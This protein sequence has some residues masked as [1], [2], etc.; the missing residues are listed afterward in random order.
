M[1][2]SWACTCYCVCIDAEKTR[3]VLC[4]RPDW[5]RGMHHKQSPRRRQS[6]GSGSRQNVPEWECN[7]KQPTMQSLIQ[8]VCFRYNTLPIVSRHTRIPASIDTRVHAGRLESKGPMAKLGQTLAGV[9]IFA[10]YVRGLGVK[11]GVLLWGSHS[12]DYYG[13]SSP[14]VSLAHHLLRWT[15]LF[16]ALCWADSKRHH[17][18]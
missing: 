12:D 5:P 18:E 13:E 14:L 6:V 8:Q 17:K 3:I 7:G 9:P 1:N 2:I 16:A 15:L 11:P 4:R 10:W